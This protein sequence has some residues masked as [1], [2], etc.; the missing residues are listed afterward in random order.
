MAEE[1]WANI[2]EHEDGVGRL[3]NVNDDVI[4]CREGILE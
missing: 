2:I 3:L 4:A 1:I